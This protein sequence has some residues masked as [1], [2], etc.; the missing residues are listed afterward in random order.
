MPPFG[1]GLSIANLRGA[2]GGASPPAVT[3]G[4]LLENGTDF[5]LLENGDY[6]LQG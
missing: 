2:G 1:F 3:D 4:I 5:L 6:L